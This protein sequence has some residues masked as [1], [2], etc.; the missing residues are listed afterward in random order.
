MNEKSKKTIFHKIFYVPENIDVVYA[1][2]KCVLFCLT[3]AI[4]SNNTELFENHAKTHQILKAD[5]IFDFRLC[6]S[7]F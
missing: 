1:N 4:T 3:K 2:D 5:F 7:S 6:T